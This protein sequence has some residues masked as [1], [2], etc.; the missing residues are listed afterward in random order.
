MME[1]M[2]EEVKR[3]IEKAWDTRYDNR[4]EDIVSNCCSAPAL[5]FDLC[6]DCKEHAEFVDLN[7]E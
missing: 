6:S 7:E 5:Y 1:T 3:I 2:T 4:E